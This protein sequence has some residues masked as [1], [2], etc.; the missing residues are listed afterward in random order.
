MIELVLLCGVGA[1]VLSTLAG[2]GGGLVALL[3]LSAAMG[4]R[5]ALVLTAPGLAVAN[6]H[7]AWLY[8]RSIDRALV[9]RML[10]P[11]LVASGLVGALAV[12]A[13]AGLLRA[14]LVIA[15]ALAL[16]KAVGWLRFTVSPALFA[17]AGAAIG[18]FGACSGGAGLLLSPVLV[19]AGLEG[20]AFVATTQVLALGLNSGRMV[21]YFAGGSLTAKVL[22]MATA[23][24]LALLVGNS[25]GH[26]VRGWLDKKQLRTIELGTMALATALVALGF[27]A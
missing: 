8:R 13:P 18:A 23:L 3:A 12:R 21:G 4:P 5:E 16:A 10:A 27:R 6:I 15:T 9:R 19:S 24:L 2:Q 25:L 7:R 22:P 14:L 11:I 26:A 1:G 20:E 17:P